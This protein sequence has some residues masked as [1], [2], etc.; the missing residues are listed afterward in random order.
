MQ[1]GT[2]M[3]VLKIQAGVSGQR[4]LRD[5]KDDVLQRFDWTRSYCA[6]NTN[7]SSITICVLSNSSNTIQSCIHVKILGA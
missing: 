3:A 6:S 1:T 4:C 2:F 7:F 5:S